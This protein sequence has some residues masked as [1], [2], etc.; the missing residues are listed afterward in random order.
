MVHVG[1]QY[2][3]NN[4]V[5]SRNFNAVSWSCGVTWIVNANS[6]GR[7][8]FMDADASRL[9]AGVCRVKLGA[10]SRDKELKLRHNT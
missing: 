3:L 8:L 9:V 1:R 5:V 6:I 10:L 4:G 2:F 7:L